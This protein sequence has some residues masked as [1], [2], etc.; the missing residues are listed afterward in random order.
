MTILHQVG[1]LLHQAVVLW[2]YYT[3]LLYYDHNTTAWYKVHQADV[4]IYFLKS[5]VYFFVRVIL[6]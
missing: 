1:V 5:V 2:S 6:P 3:R 4:N